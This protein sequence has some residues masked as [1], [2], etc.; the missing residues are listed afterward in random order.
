MWYIC[1]SSNH[2]VVMHVCV[3]DVHKERMFWLRCSP[4]YISQIVSICMEKKEKLTERKALKNLV[5][6][7]GFMFHVIDFKAG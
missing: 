7:T 1:A 5:M 3:L 2:V 6:E 4:V